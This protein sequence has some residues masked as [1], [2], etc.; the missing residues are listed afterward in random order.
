MKLLGQ[1]ISMVNEQT[2][3]SSSHFVTLFSSAFH[4]IAVI[5]IMICIVSLF[6]Y[7]DGCKCGEWRECWRTC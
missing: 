2:V 7:P 3:L 1:M 6:R 4:S 5:S